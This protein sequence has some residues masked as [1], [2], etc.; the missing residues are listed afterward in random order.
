M[1]PYTCVRRAARNYGF[2][3]L[4]HDGAIAEFRI[5]DRDDPMYGAERTRKLQRCGQ[6]LRNR[7]RHR[8]S[9]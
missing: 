1:S 8:V 7:V 5:A 2:T 4:T 3:V 9:A 6:T